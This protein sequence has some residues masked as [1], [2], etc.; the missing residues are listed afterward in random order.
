MR[1]KIALMTS[2]AAL[3]ALI[4]ATAL[5]QD[6]APA[7][8][9]PAPPP[10]PAPAA[11]ESPQSA[12]EA[13]PPASPAPSVEPAPAAPAAWPGW[14]RA[15]HDGGGLQLWGG[16]TAPLADGIG[17]AYDMYVNFGGPALGEF[18]IGPAIAVSTLTLT[19]MLGAQFNWNDRTFAA[20]VPQLYL[21][22][23]FGDG[24]FY[25]ELWI[26]YY[27]YKLVRETGL[28]TYL[29]LRAFADY[30]ISDNV[31]VGPQIELT[32]N[33]TQEK[34]TSLPIGANVMLNMG[35]NSTFFMFL[36]YET[37]KN[38]NTYPTGSDAMGNPTGTEKHNVAGRLTF[39]HNF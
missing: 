1:I 33:F 3:G 9:A 39:V 10:A 2:L 22:G 24:K 4:P 17:L 20:L 14:I 29:Y 8:T 31:G 12:A 30:K 21:T 28:D 7:A 32:Q 38:S 37:N 13:S 36:G 6:T 34:L 35:L 11:A 15:D 23:P 26:Q 19:P 18:D 27:N 16:A 5:A 25:E